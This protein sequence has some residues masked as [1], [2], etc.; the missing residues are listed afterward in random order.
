M[1]RTKETFMDWDY[2]KDEDRGNYGTLATKTK[3]RTT[4]RS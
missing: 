1:S 2:V 4:T 3:T